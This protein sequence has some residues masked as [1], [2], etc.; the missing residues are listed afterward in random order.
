M[1][2]QTVAVNRWWSNCPSQVPKVASLSSLSMHR[3]SPKYENWGVSECRIK[4]TICVLNVAWPCNHQI[5]TGKYCWAYLTLLTYISTIK[6]RHYNKA[7]T[8]LPCYIDAF[9]WLTH[10]WQLNVHTK[11]SVFQTGDIKSLTT[12]RWCDCR[13]MHTQLKSYIVNQFH[14]YLLQCP[15]V[16]WNV[17]DMT[18]LPL[19]SSGEV[20]AIR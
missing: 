7:S 9:T 3:V 1:Q 13:H 19:P 4:W 5:I 16:M 2:A 10:Y 18:P 20:K 8:F 17:A 15:T 12:D 14:K 6:C 11:N